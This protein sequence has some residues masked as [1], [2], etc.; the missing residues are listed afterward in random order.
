VDDG[1]NSSSSIPEGSPTSVSIISR[2]D[3]HRPDLSSL[4]LAI[5]KVDTRRHAKRY[6][7]TARAT[8]A[9]SG[10][11]SVSV[12]LYPRAVEGEELGLSR[13]DPPVFTATLRRSAG[14]P[15]DGT[16]SGVLR[17]GRCA[18]IG[19]YDVL[20]DVSDHIGRYR[21]YHGSRLTALGVPAQVDIV[22]R[23]R[24]TFLPT[25]GRRALSSR[26]IVVVFDEGVVNVTARNLRLIDYHPAARVVDVTRR[27]LDAQRHRISCSG[28]DAP[29]RRVVLT[30]APG[31]RLRPVWRIDANP[32]GAAPQITDTFGNPLRNGVLRL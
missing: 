7:V 29:V 14:S 5:T 30:I 32:S 19:T 10:V 6:A 4:R 16:W 9:E 13:A 1:I 24:D 20:A 3:R 23:A 25:I 27:C 22:S 8:D 15:A 2:A 28:A 18:R 31:I 17:V 26:R 11:E 12:T 21:G